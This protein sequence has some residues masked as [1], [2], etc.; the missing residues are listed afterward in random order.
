ME[1][2][3]TKEG[4]F[5]KKQPWQNLKLLASWIVRKEKSLLLK[6]P[7]LW[8][9]VMTA[10]LTCQKEQF[11][12]IQLYTFFRVAQSQTQLKWPNTHAYAFF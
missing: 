11:H 2:K 1:K 5:R 7:S 10:K 9:C 4:G 3:D 6:L 8:Y 12:K